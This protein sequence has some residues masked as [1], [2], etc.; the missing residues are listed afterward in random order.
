MKP[1][2][3]IVPLFILS[4]GCGLNL[5]E[6]VHEVQEDIEV[7]VDYGVSDNE[8]D[9]RLYITNHKEEE[10]AFS[11]LGN[12][13]E[14]EIYEN[15]EA[16]IVDREPIDDVPVP[17][18]LDSGETVEGEELS[19]VTLEEGNEYEIN[20]HFESTFQLQQDE[21]EQWDLVFDISEE[22]SGETE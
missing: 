8:L 3:V 5:K 17:Y 6:N 16:M 21:E 1:I 20:V 10:I 15:G 14:I 19:G 18:F 22:V 13:T 2:T 12:L 4:A 7:G 11:A 9:A